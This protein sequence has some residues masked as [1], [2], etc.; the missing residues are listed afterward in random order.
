MVYYNSIAILIIKFDNKKR[1]YN[2]QLPN[3]LSSPIPLYIKLI[4][5]YTKTAFL[6]M[7]N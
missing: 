6:Y 2:N 7:I 5:L 3:N 4:D 1:T